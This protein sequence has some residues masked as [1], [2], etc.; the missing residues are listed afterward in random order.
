MSTIL[1][2]EDDAMVRSNVVELLE[3][4]DY[5]V[6]SAESG[7]AGV[8]QA[9]RSL[10]DLIVCDVTMPGI[11]G[12]E[13]FEMLS[14]RPAT[15]VI[16]FIFLSARAE[17]RDV[18]RGMALGAGDYLTKPFTRVELLDSI[19]A[20]LKRK[21]AATEPPADVAGSTSN[22]AFESGDP[23]RLDDELV[24]LDRAMRG[25]V[26]QAERAA[27][28]PFSILLLG[29]T[30]VGKEVIAEHVHHCSRRKGRFVPLNCAALT[31]SLLESELFG[32]EKGAFTGAVHAKEGLFEAAE[33]GTLFLDEVGELPVTVQAKLLRVLEARQVLRVGGRQA[34]AIDVRFVSATNRDLEAAVREGNF[35]QDLFFRLNGFSL[36]IPPLRERPDDI[37]PLARRFVVLASQALQRSRVPTLDEQGLAALRRY[38][39]PG[40]IRELRN[41]IERAVLLCEGDEIGAEAFPFKSSVGQGSAG[42][43]GETDDPRA[44]LMQEIERAERARIVEALERCG[45]NQTHAAALLGISRRTLVTRLGLYDLPR[46]RKRELA[47]EL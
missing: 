1:V 43:A 29:E 21:L 20:R 9:V 36:T 17:R 42:D 45:H 3:A 25:I 14:S 8:E 35:R 41:V 34:R 12:F 30:G 11:D 37:A 27:A 22:A 28:S 2:I 10:P 32:H 7:E 16:P 6:T 18:R 4:E 40:N 38:A 24:V 26:A 15:A 44:R 31:E 19:K 46:P 5:T 47:D 39:W 23:P 33:G 13:V